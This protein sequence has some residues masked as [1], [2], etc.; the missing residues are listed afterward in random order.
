[1]KSGQQNLLFNNGFN[2][3]KIKDAHSHIDYIT[4]KH[5]NCVVGTICCTNDESQWAILADM[6]KSDTNIYGAFG[7]HPWFVNDVLDGFEIRLEQLLKNNSDYMVGEIGLDK[8]KTNMDKQIDMFTKQFDLAIK[9]K[10]VV[11]LHC[12]GAW[13]KI[14]HIL[15]QYKKSELPIIVAHAFNGNDDILQKLLQ[16]NNIIFSF[17]KIDKRGGFGCIEQIS[18]NRILVESDGKPNSDLVRLVQLITD[19]KKSVNMS[20]IIYDNTQRVIKNG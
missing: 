11:F 6:I 4:H 18:S 10:R 14:L 17:N 20:D 1:M 15:K 3:M 8:Y 7:V 2:T 13:D 9:L 16:Y 12:V 5:Q 19:I